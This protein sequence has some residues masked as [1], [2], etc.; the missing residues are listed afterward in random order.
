MRLLRISEKPL[1]FHP[2]PH[3]L[4]SSSL[5]AG[6]PVVDD[7][8]EVQERD[9]LELGVEEQVGEDGV[10]HEREDE[11]ERHVGEGGQCLEPP[12][13]RQRDGRE[14][15]AQD[16]ERLARERPGA[17]V[18]RRLGHVEQELDEETINVSVNDM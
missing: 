12:L 18:L 14:L 3:T 1:E 2:L 11:E 5:V 8:G 15:D 7:E 17:H 6:V 10:V 9:P 16:L 13:E 4:A